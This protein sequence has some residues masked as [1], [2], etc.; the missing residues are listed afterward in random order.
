LSGGARARTVER[1]AEFLI[2]VYVSRS[3]EATVQRDAKQARR[4]AE[5]VTREGTPVRFMRSIFVPDD[6]TCFH[7]YE[8]ASAECVR[9]AAV[10]AALRFER[11]SEAIGIETEGAAQ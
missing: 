2:E 8:A 5:Q 10:R 3:D 6:E 7:V 1:M 11:V 4:A 9:E